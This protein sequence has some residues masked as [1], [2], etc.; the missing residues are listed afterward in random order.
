M[1]VKGI[2][3]LEQHFEKLVLAIACVVLLGV[4]ALQFVGTP[5]T[6]ESN[7]RTVTPDKV[8]LALADQANSVQSQITDS[9]PALPDVDDVNLLARY[10]AALASDTTQRSLP[11]EFADGVDIASVLGT[12]ID[13][14]PTGPSEI[15]AMSVPPTARPIA[16]SQWATLDPY[17]ADQVP[18]YKD[19]A[20]S[21][22]PMDF[23]SVTIEAEFSG[24]DLRGVLNGAGGNPGVPRTFWVSTGMA[25]M[26]LDVERQR[27]NPDGSWGPGEPIL[28]PPGQAIATNAV[29]PDNGLVRLNETIANAT[30]HGEAVQRP[31]FPPTISG[32]EWTPPSERGGVTT[33]SEEE[34][35]QRRLTRLEREIEQLSSAPTRRTTRG[36]RDDR[37]SARNPRGTTTTSRPSGTDL[38][39]ARVDQLEEQADDIRD[40]L[41]RLGVDTRDRDDPPPAPRLLDQETVQLWTHDLGVEPGAT[42]RYRTRAAVNNP[43]FRKGPYLD[44]ADPDQQAL[45]RDPFTFGQWS[46]WSE[47]VR[48]GDRSVYFVSGA[49]QGAGGAQPEARVELYSMY[50]GF[51][52]RKTQTVKPGQLLVHESSVPS[53]LLLIDTQ[54][55]EA[56]DVADFIASGE[57]S[58]PPEGV[59]QGQSRIRR[60]LGTSV[61]EINAV[62][63]MAGTP[64]GYS[65]LFRDADGTLVR[66]SPVMDQNSVIYDQISSSASTGARAGLRPPG[67]RP[68]RSPVADLFEPVDP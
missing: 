10:D 29:R 64:G 45:T 46:E 21:S 40:R 17:A 63:T 43:Y 16:A 50:Y 33:L 53:D 12:R 67:T 38:R 54:A 8:Y 34:Q 30:M 28:T 47:P 5:N 11:V 27:Q 25:V 3:P 44:T 59:I 66:R 19:I 6:V 60:V 61:I 20:G 39:E 22:Q 4:L 56:E 18:A 24:T 48:V 55:V 2:N 36:T 51:Y 68:A 62:P 31:A 23:A 9:S 58:A 42:Y 35:L 14:T 1:K 32:V 52:R 49:D 37:G 7:G 41:D 13:A 65:V 26:E 57:R 15:A